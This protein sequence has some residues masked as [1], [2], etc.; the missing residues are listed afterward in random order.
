MQELPAK[1]P[2][3]E[4]KHA[5]LANY[6]ERWFGVMSTRG[7]INR[8]LIVDGFC[9][10]GK[11]SGG[12]DGS[13]L[14][15]LRA[16]ARIRQPAKQVELI[17]IDKDQEAIQA[18]SE[19]VEPFRKVGHLTINLIHGDFADVAP[20]LVN[21]RIDA[22]RHVPTFA[23]IDPFGWSGVDFAVLEKMFELQSAEILFNL[24][25]DSINRFVTGH[26]DPSIQAHFAKM[27]SD[28]AR[29]RI[30]HSSSRPEAIKLEFV[31]RLQS[32]SKYV[33]PFTM[34]VRGRHFNDLV[35]AG[36]H[37]RGNVLMKEVMYGV[38]KD[39]D[40]FFVDRRFNALIDGMELE[41]ISNQVVHD[42]I[43]PYLQS[44]PEAS[45]GALIDAVSEKPR[46]V[47]RHVKQGLVR[48]EDAG[49]IVVDP[50]KS[51]GKKRHGKSFPNTVIV[52]LTAKG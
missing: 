35:W 27:F 23:F 33:L 3:T 44:V 48:A 28:E 7:D 30:A 51:D 2:H 36:N 50:F 47:E 9:G 8:L 52:R 26:P 25:T 37:V 6:L 13:P 41:V 29:S 17:F 46:Y 14:I 12:E 31:S 34:R 15:A 18:L 39:V 10:P 49:I 19:L 11:Y 42:I 40:F 38:S 5:L 1:Q 43:I 22:A 21:E 32:I 4:A 24:M 45:V 16:A 20:G